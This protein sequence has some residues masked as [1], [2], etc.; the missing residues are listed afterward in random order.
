MEDSIIIENISNMMGAAVEALVSILFPVPKEFPTQ[1][2]TVYSGVVPMHQASRL[3]LEVPVF[4]AIF[5]L[6]E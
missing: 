2:A 6:R 3:P 4:H 5:F 1:T